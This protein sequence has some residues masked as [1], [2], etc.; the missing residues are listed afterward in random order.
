M[1]MGWEG[2]Q[3]IFGVNAFSFLTGIILALVIGL[4]VA[5]L[6][7]SFYTLATVILG[8]IIGGNAMGFIAVTLGLQ[9]DGFLTLLLALA[10]AIIVGVAV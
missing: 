1:V 2:A 7:Y 3:A 5:A 8:A 9:E 6:A 4:I 10:G